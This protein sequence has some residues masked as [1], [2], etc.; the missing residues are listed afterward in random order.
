MAWFAWFRRDRAKSDESASGIVSQ[1]VRA[2]SSKGPAT[3]ISATAL[4]FSGF[5]LWETSLKQA[6]LSVY[7]TGVVTY[8]RDRAA[9]DSIMPSGG[10]EVLAVPITIA[11]GGA[12]DGV[13]LAL[14]LDVNNPKTGLAARFEATYSAD[15]AYF[16]KTGARPK[17]PFSALVIAGRSGWTGTLLFYP[18]SYSNEKSLTPVRQ[19]A[20]LNDDLRKRYASEME[21]RSSISVLREKRPDL[22]EFAD[23]DAYGAKVLNGSDK[24]ELA[25]KLIRP[26]ST[27]WLDRVLG[28][29]VQPITLTLNMPDISDYQMGRG[30]LVRLRTA[31]ARP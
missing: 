18:V 27:S 2:G 19:I 24:V 21:G 6:D 28:T 4:C 25:L 9:D 23:Y 11:N 26:P 22:P 30:E 7:V 5:S 1:A 14:Q 17:A 8:E 20:A 29:Q 12:R 16:A 10:F 13:V 3:V 15:A 31:T